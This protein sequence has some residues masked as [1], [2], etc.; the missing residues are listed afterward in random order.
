M[1]FGVAKDIITPVE[2]TMLTC[3]GVYNE[4]YKE[5]HD[6][7]F[8]RCL[9]IDDGKR[10]AVLM[11]FDLIFH[12]RTLNREIARYAKEKHGID[13]AA[14]VLTHTHSHTTPSTPSYNRYNPM[15]RNEAFEK[16]L[17]D[18]A[19]DCLDR[20]MYTMFEGEMEYG[21]FDGDFNVS[22]RGKVNGKYK[23]HP[24]FDYICDKEFFVLRVTDTRGNLRSIVCNYP[25]HPVFYPSAD[26]LSGE[27]P[28]RLS[29]L[30]EC[31]YYGAVALYTQSSAGDV[32][33]LT[34]VDYKDD[35]SLGFKKL[36]FSG[37]DEFAKMMFKSVCDFLNNGS[38]KSVDATLA[39]DEFT[40]ELEI[41]P[42]PIS[43]F[44][45][46]IE[47]EKAKPVPAP[48]NSNWLN[49][50][51][52]VAGGYDDLPESVT[53]HCQT[54]KICDSLYIATVGGEPCFGV[55]NAVKAAFGESDVL[56]IG[57]T[58]D[59]AYL[60]DDRV[61]SEGGYEPECHIEYNLK[62]P[63]KSG[64]DDKYTSGFKAS[65]ERIG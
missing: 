42:A 39:A 51:H 17:F 31:E 65:F 3:T 10:K 14:V 64:L 18:R 16:L 49:A 38:F 29:Q 37:V 35:G 19:K 25:C 61:L 15:C 36:P 21:S 50:E 24:N 62:G 59:C 32:R 4:T 57:Y 60:V 34:A 41:E 5:I 7:I 43:A 8:V 30:L 40:I 55:K 47:Y 1:R 23:I 52:A 46:R 44:E 13:P 28:G 26:E 12:D 11:A 33:P 63:F 56:F 6:D 45:A 9:V 2:P 58:D 54:L 22:R 48:G 20:A 27:F 53:L